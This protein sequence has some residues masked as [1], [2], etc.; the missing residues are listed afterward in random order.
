MVGEDVKAI[1]FKNKDSAD[2]WLLIM[3]VEPN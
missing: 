1:R 2:V 3:A